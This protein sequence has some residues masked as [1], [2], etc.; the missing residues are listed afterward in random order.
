MNST[1]SL[2]LESIEKV[3]DVA[4]FFVAYKANNAVL[5]Q[6]R[7]CNFCKP[8]VKQIC[9][10]LSPKAWHYSCLTT[11]ASKIQATPESLHIKSL[12]NR[13]THSAF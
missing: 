3:S 1:C 8:K 5:H 6:T 12:S 7:E 10:N 2:P 9:L 4:A 13:A 11:L